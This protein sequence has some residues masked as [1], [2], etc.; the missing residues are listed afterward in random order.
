MK[1]APPVRCLFHIPFR[2]V[3]P[4]SLEALPASKQALKEQA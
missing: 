4:P 1:K 2:P 3:A